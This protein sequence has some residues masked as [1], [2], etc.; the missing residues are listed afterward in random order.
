[1]IFKFLILS[2]EVDDFAREISIDSEATFLELNDAILESVNYT[3]DQ[4]TSFFICEDDWEKKTEITLMEMD[5]NFE[6][7]S[8]VM[9]ETRLSELLEDE[10]Q[11]LIFVFDNMT[12]RSFF[13]EL[14][15]IIPGKNLDKAVCSKSLGS[16][17]AQLMT[18]DELDK[19]PGSTDIGLGENFYGDESFDPSE[20]DDEGY[21]DLDISEDNGSFNEY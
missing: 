3:K 14:R 20:L 2:D 18:F 7:D 16:A 13:M 19:T 12:E 4:M 1:M 10:K 8:W 5:T 15:E 9:A 17:P 11:R 21:N 6:D